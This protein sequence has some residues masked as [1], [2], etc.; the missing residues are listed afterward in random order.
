MTGLLVPVAVSY[1]Q[2]SAAAM[3]L[4]SAAVEFETAVGGLTAQRH[5]AATVAEASE[6]MELLHNAARSAEEASRAA[7]HAAD[8]TS[9]LDVNITPSSNNAACERE[10][11][12]V[13]FHEGAHA[14]FCQR[15]GFPMVEA[16]MKVCRWSLFG[17][18]SG[19]GYVWTAPIE[20]R[21]CQMRDWAAMHFAGAEAYAQWL[22]QVEHADLKAARR[23]AYDRATGDMEMV[24][25][26]LGGDRR[27]LRAAQRRAEELVP[28]W[29]DSIGSVAAELREQKRLSAGQIARAA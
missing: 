16:K 3:R 22:H 29:W 15:F 2:V 6:A 9:R 25:V 5:D 7:A 23:K 14:V 11:H 28:V 1:D 4:R 13:S 17:N 8:L 20:L 27:E 21:E 18:P 24:S 19:G 12:L 26:D 10:N